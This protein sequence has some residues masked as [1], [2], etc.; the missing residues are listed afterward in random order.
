[1]MPAAKHGDPQLGVDIHLCTVPP[2]VPAPLPTPHMSVVF[3]PF[4]YVP[5]LGAT[6]SVCGMKRA[7]AGTNATVIHIPPGFPFAPKLPDKDDELFMGAATVVADGDPFSFVGLPVLGC[8]VAGMPS[9]PRPRKKGGPKA[10]LLPTDVNLAIPTN[11]VIGGPPTISLMGMASK[12][13]FAALGRF[14]KAFK[15]LRQKVFKNMKPGF[16]K[17]TILRAEP[18]NIITGEVSVEQQD[19]A[20]PGRLP[21]Q[22]VRTYTSNNPRRGVCGVGWETPA[23]ARIEFD[24]RDG[25][26]MFLHPSAGPAL[27]PSAPRAQGD[28][29]AV[30]EIWDGALLSDHGHEF[31]VRTKEDRVYHFPKAGRARRDEQLQEYVVSRLSDLC[32]NWLHFT[33]RDGQLSASKIPRAGASPSRARRA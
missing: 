3:D 20:L 21:L 4:D 11:V 17:C 13:G 27:F 2:G 5:I 6:V 8:Q 30:L 33:R 16:L 19:F 12:A 7:T 22:W 28:A 23:D 32:G 31:R 15:K 26:V 14:A 29:H 18:V 24:E 9:P 1:M 10:M 25:T